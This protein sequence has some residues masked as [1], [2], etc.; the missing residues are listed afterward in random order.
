MSASISAVTAQP[1]RPPAAAG[2][3]ASPSPTTGR[4]RETV[5]PVPGDKAAEA[6][7]TQAG[8]ALA[9]INQSLQMALIGV[10]FEFDKEA[11][12]LIAK[13]VDVET[14]E[15]IRQMPSAEMVRMS[16]ALDQLQGLLVS[17]K[18]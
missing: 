12:T 6:T 13:V 14:G 2:L 5:A 15:V 11:D 7:P 1:L 17:Q 8:A 3:S 4:V 10:Q 18:V 16:K 9:E